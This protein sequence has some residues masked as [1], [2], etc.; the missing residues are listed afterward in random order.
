[1]LTTQV[2]QHYF[3]L[4]GEDG[5]GLTTNPGFVKTN[6]SGF[7]QI[8]N[9]KNY[10]VINVIQERSP[11]EIN[12]QLYVDNGTGYIPTN[13]RVSLVRDDYIKIRGIYKR[14]PRSEVLLLVQSQM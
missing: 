13:L 9:K 12:E 5:V 8:V 3:Q 1:M 10:P 4:V 7:A 6:Q 11:F 2:Q 14:V